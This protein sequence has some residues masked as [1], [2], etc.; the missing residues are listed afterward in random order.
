MITLCWISKSL[1]VNLDS[2]M[3]RI[4]HTCI[5]DRWHGFRCI[6]NSCLVV[7]QM[8]T[9]PK[10][11]FFNSVSIFFALHAIMRRHL[12]IFGFGFARMIYFLY[13]DIRI[14]LICASVY[15]E[16]KIMGSMLLLYLIVSKALDLHVCNSFL[17][18]CF[19]SDHQT[20]LSIYGLDMSLGAII[21]PHVRL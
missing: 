1:I 6:M 3:N 7:C 5:A 11:R 17:I 2:R 14:L 16:S 9:S 12:V 21:M 15:I 4:R 19:T 18:V 8:I 20:L 13:Q 10:F